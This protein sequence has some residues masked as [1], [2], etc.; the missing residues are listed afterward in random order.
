[1]FGGI[2]RN[3]NHFSVEIYL[4]AG[5][6]KPIFIAG[7]WVP[8]ICS[9]Y[10]IGGLVGVR[11]LKCIGRFNSYTGF[12]RSGWRAL[13]DVACFQEGRVSRCFR[14]QDQNKLDISEEVTN[15]SNS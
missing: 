2:Y 15:R 11:C 6:R 3:N 4:A 10:C 14:L 5:F 9:Y 7:E 8:T 1:M 12:K 13:G